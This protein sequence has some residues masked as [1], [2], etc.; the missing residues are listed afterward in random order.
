MTLSGQSNHEMGDRGLNGWQDVKVA[1]SSYSNSLSSILKGEKEAI[2]TYYSK[3][4]IN[5]LVKLELNKDWKELSVHS[6]DC[7]KLQVLLYME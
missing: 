6:K 7:H 2:F 4:V 1:R 5:M 3:V